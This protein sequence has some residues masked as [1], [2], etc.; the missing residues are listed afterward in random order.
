MHGTTQHLR[1]VPDLAVRY[2]RV[3]QLSRA[4]CAPLSA[5][6]CLVQSMPDASPSK[7][8][9][10]HT[11]WFFETFVLCGLEHYREF[12]S[13]YRSLFNSYYN[14]V[15]AQYPRERRGLLSRPDLHTVWRYRQHVDEAIRRALEYGNLNAARRDA[16]ELGLHHE[17]QHQE[18]M[19]SDIKH[20]LWQNP[21]A[22]RYHPGPG[23][24]PV[25]TAPQSKWL[26]FDDA[27]FD[28]GHGEPSFC[29]DNEQPQHRVFSPAFQIAPRLVTNKEMLE[30]IED[31][32]Y[33]RHELWL[34]EGFA[35]VQHENIRHPLYWLYEDDTWKN[36]TLYGLGEL[37]CNT[38]VCH[39]S[40]YEADAFARWAQA[41]LATECEHERAAASLCAKDIESAMAQANL[42]DEDSATQGRLHPT[43]HGSHHGF[44]GDAWE[45]T[46][47]SYAPYPGF[48]PQDG[49]LG[50]YNGK[51]MCNQQVLRGGS[52]ATPRGH[53]RPSYRNF[54]PAGT[55]W[56]FST[57][58]LAKDHE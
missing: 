19:L 38:P 6:D 14:T 41:R 31:G 22:G 8:H 42:L 45:W 3:R 55:R 50:E 9:L 57:I 48:K 56:Q 40:Y 43:G 44:F 52:C 13:Q 58:R 28:M 32:G 26:R 10:A 36:F 29:F 12:D 5:E 33:Q 23:P 18:L 27:L 37:D 54:F 47:S 24:A 20:A 25:S 34:S 15:G 53:L 17:Q 16:I 11:T 51:F 21:H 7:W 46:Q 2:R 30:F 39:L 4:L 1:P 49:A 35:W